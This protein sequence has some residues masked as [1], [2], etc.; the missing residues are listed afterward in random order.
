ME[1]DLQADGFRILRDAIPESEILALRTYCESL[2]S[3]PSPYEQDIENDP[4]IG[5]IR[6]DLISRYPKLADVFFNKDLIQALHHTLGDEIILFP[7]TGV[8]K[9]GFGDWHKDIDSN[10]RAGIFSHWDDDF[11][12]YTC[13]I[14]LQ[15]NDPEFA[16]GLEVIPGSH[17]SKLRWVEQ[18]QRG[19]VIPTKPEDI[20]YFHH[21]MDHR[22]TH[23]N[24]GL[25]S[26]KQ[27]LDARRDKYGI[28]FN[29][30]AA[31]RHAEIYINFL[32][33]RPHYVWMKNFVVNP[34][35]EAKARRNGVRVAR[36]S[37]GPPVQIREDD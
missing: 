15:D 20:V 23:P 32:R 10:E 29:V 11:K 31:N 33:S 5:C 18:H 37:A 25:K 28:F 1:P 36:P 30:S 6:L 19:F 14:Y 13:A 22:A 17:H 8:H 16:G 35:F 4:K 26:V 27:P 2:F 3:Q 24:P 7:E 21:R 34:E 9:N 12:I